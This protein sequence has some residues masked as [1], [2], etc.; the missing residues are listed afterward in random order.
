M[1]PNRALFDKLIFFSLA[2]SVCFLLSFRPIPSLTSTNDTGRYVEEF[3]SYCSGAAGARA[4]KNEISYSLFFLV[5]NPACLGMS[6]ALFLFEVSIFVPLIFLLFSKWRIGTFF[7][8]CAG[9]ISVFG[10]ELMTNAMRQ[11]FALLLFVGS[12][13]ALERNKFWAVILA[14]LAMASHTT[15]AVYFLYFLWV[16]GFHISK[17]ICGVFVFILSILLFFYFLIKGYSLPSLSADLFQIA[18]RYNE[19]YSIELN[20]FFIVFMVVP[21]FWVYFIRYL[22]SKHGV[23][24]KEK[25]AIIF[26]SALLVVSYFLTP[27]VT[28]RFAITGI[29]L[30]LFLAT[31]SDV[32][33]LGNSVLIFVGMFFHLLVMIVFS[34]QYSVL[35][36]G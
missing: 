31:R 21:L 28:F 11:G 36:H 33:K 25:K 16:S 23:T 8:A 3:Y 20:A 7:L 10:L 1:N 27:Y 15:T 4:S 6:E 5:T 14:L 12:V 9:V 13:A 22:F 2:F 18:L 19:I 30:Q 32:Q 34:D 17:K 24:S 29:I 26:S 35:I